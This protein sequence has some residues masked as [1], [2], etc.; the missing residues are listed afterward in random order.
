MK[1][2]IVLLVV[3]LFICSSSVLEAP[4]A[5]EN[6]SMVSAGV[7]SV[8][9]GS[10]VQ[11]HLVYIPP[12]EFMMGDNSYDI[13]KPVH[14][15]KI[16]KGFYLGMH[17]VTQEQYEAVKSRNPSKFKGSKNPVETVTWKDAVWFCKTL[18]DKTDKV[19]RL[20]TEAEWEYA[21]RA[22][23]TGK[24]CFGD[25]ERKLKKY[26]WYNRCWW[27]PKKS[28]HPVG[29]KKPNAWGLYDMHGNVWEWCNDWI[30]HYESSPAT[31][32]KGPENPAYVRHR[33]IRS[34]SFALDPVFL[35]S[36]NRAGAEVRHVEE[37]RSS[38]G[39]RCVQESE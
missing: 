29:Q 10:G 3:V 17:E 38:I 37:T 13:E 8:D 35:R 16:T 5:L 31:D 32:P 20:P 36:A 2:I 27:W 22:G 28:T 34:G 12:G 23:S 19:F 30:D 25:D 33:V 39:F 9:L 1:R 7:I 15:V 21:C 14:R 18:S 24:W 6:R 26:G 4:K 11:M